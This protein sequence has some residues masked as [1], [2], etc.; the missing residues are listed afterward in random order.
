[1][2]GAI[3]HEHSKGGK[4]ASILRIALIRHGPT[5]WNEEGRIQGQMDL[6]LSEAG[7]AKMAALAPP[8]GFEKAR[9]FSS[10]LG[11]AIETAKLLGLV[12]AI[13]ARLIE[14]HW[15]RWEGKTR[16]EILAND[17]Q[18]AF[19]RAGR[20]AEFKPAGGERT[21]D[22]IARVRSF[23]LDV[24]AGDTDAVAITHRGVLRSG[25]ALATGWQMTTPMPDALDL[26][27]VLILEV[28][29]RAIKI[30]DLNVSLPRK[31]PSP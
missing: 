5:A 1:L 4:A 26:T 29:D 10:P 25:Y 17:G 20:G 13:D 3:L 23:L 8:A 16:E 9:S 14:H 15:G 12:P 19:E 30:S 27:K 7:R 28:R 6:P 31:L 2:R 22:L 24:G 11:R 18:D 21:A